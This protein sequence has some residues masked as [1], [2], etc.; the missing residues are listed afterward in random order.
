M[1]TLACFEGEKKSKPNMVSV[2][3]LCFFPPIALRYQVN[4]QI[5][6]GRQVIKPERQGLEA[7]NVVLRL[8]LDS[9]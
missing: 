3:M 9:F 8:D 4:K 1:Q 5:M 6:D 2:K 7:A